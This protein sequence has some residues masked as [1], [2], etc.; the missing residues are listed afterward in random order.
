ME[1]I[2]GQKMEMLSSDGNCLQEVTV[3]KVLKAPLLT[4]EV[5][6]TVKPYGGNKRFTFRF[7]PET[8]PRLSECKKQFLYFNT[9]EERKIAVDLFKQAYELY[10]QQRKKTRELLAGVKVS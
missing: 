2:K 6:V 9:P 3:T 8:M 1:I 4:N 7:G 10:H 5:F